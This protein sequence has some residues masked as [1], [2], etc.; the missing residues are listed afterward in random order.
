VGI[1]PTEA[2][3]ASC[4]QGVSVGCPGSVCEGGRTPAIAV[5]QTLPA[6]GSVQVM[7]AGRQIFFRGERNPNAQEAR[8]LPRRR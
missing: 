7:R 2:A 6:G 1:R 5:F 4:L 3:Q 8:V